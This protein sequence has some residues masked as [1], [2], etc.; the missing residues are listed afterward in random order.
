MAIGNTVL[1]LLA[2]RLADLA[3]YFMV[4]ASDLD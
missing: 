3:S 4:S 2:A 1:Y